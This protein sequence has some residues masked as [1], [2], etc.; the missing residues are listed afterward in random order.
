[1]YKKEKKQVN[2]FS[3]LTS[4]QAEESRRL[5]GHN[6][7][8]PPERI[9]W[10]KL[11][12]EK[13][14]DPV[15]RILIIAAGIAIAIGFA[16]GSYIEGVG[17]IMAI[18]LATTL[19][20]LN[21]FKAAKEFDIL[22]QVRDDEPVKVIRD[23]VYTTIS[24][25]DVVVG[26]VTLV[27]VGDEIPAD[28]KV[29]EAVSLQVNES[30][31]TGESKP[32]AKFPA[33]SEHADTN[34]HHAYGQDFLLRGTA[35]I[36]GYGLYEVTAVGDKT[37][38]GKTA[39][40]ASE[41]TGNQTPLNQQL[42][43]L[44]KIIGIAGF[45]I[46]GITFA[47]LMIR[48]IL[49]KE[50]V[51]NGQQFAAVIV[52]VLSGLL[53]LSRVW[54][55]ILFDL[56]ELTGRVKERPE[57]VKDNSLKSWGL[58]FLAG[59]VLFGI[60]TFTLGAL[61]VLSY[62]PA[63]WLSAEISSRLLKFFMIAVTLIVVAVPEGLA[64]SVTLSLAYSMRKMTATN[65]LVRKMHSVETISAATVICSDK[66]GTLTYNE[67]RVKEIHF[68]MLRTRFLQTDSFYYTDK[69][70]V[71]AIASNS[72]AN[73]S[74]EPG[75]EPKVLGNPT[76]GALLLWLHNLGVDYQI[77]RKK[78]NILRQWTFTTETKMM[79][80]YGVSDVNSKKVLYVKGAPEII[81]ARCVSFLD[82]DGIHSI[83]ES[84]T[85]IEQG[86]RTLQENA[87][88]SLG[89]AM[90]E[91]PENIDTETDI[92]QVTKNM[93]WIGYVG[94]MDPVRKEVPPAVENCLQA[95]IGVKIVT[96]DN[97]AT[98]TE[99]G[100][101]IGL[102]GKGVPAPDQVI[103]GPEF[104]ALS[105][106]EV[107]EKIDSIRVLA[108]A[109]P[110]DKLRL[111]KLLQQKDHVVAVTGDGTNDAPALNYAD[112]GLSMG[113]TGT[114]VAKEASDIILL[115][116]SFM[117]I[118]NAVMW[119]RSLYKNIQRFLLFQL[120][121][122]VLAMITVLMGPFLGIELTLTVIQMIWVNLI[123]DTFA[124]LALATQP[125]DWQVMKQKP[126][127]RKDFIVTGPMTKH[128]LAYAG[129]F[130]LII[131][132]AIFIIQ[133][134]GITSPKEMSVFFSLFVL[135][136][137]WNL[138]NAKSFGSSRSTFHKFWENKNFL[139]IVS[140]ILVFQII[141]V[142]IGGEVFRTVPLSVQEW[143]MIIGGTSVVLIIGETER[144][145]SRRKKRKS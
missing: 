62:N 41:E 113:K 22:N 95:G 10:W 54:L 133:Q 127:R 102:I 16:E 112:V 124:A 2:R 58:S 66:T 93:V 121:I 50:I 85:K 104:A 8:T 20:F 82:S 30:S 31:L 137:F 47:A 107:L 122:N 51:L 34:T 115:D 103:T 35:V 18:F 80:T 72:T 55:P 119:G 116:D 142:Q 144:F 75:H 6:L 145:I 11:Y 25:K 21:E 15:I 63:E 3:G 33:T 36:E 13:F 108:R 90:I 81:L 101:Q 37:E 57:W 125:P 140:V 132:A 14:E 139:I 67:M 68:P 100:R 19:A 46:S 123:M 109:R 24:K 128:I 28:G 74:N 69:V 60:L 65:N 70:L 9:P 117:S 38:I 111:V 17:I 48:A 27:E 120:T 126:R 64:M 45:G 83:E 135:L 88:R 91:E 26:D 131:A 49:I 130:V 42:E 1:M 86:L 56:L 53:L 7:L 78:F 23:G 61:G 4:E 141:I 96:G 77:P 84:R 97:P 114:S 73:I 92:L 59:F 110:M 129:L 136:Q 39:R 40:A 143:L 71:E 79:G 76:E 138:F 105:D 99:I 89:F 118:V 29:L 94:I 44:G 5:H 52:L 134:D 12:L 43:K 32:V 98:A 106:T 87:M